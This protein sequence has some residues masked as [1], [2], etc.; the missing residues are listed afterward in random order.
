MSGEMEL[1]TLLRFMKPKLVDGIF[2]F[3][4]TA[5]LS[6]ERVMA[7]SPIA[8]YREE[9]GVSL[10]LTEATARSAGFETEALFRCITLSVHSS[11]NAVGL[12]A[13]VATKLS[14]HGISANVVAAYYHDHVYVPASRADQALALLGGFQV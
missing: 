12:T 4:S 9:E 13:A 2:V 11:L 6:V 7:L 10:I 5:E 14:S 3:C 1:E 8:V